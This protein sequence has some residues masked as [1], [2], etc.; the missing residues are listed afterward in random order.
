V[1]ASVWDSVVGQTSAVARLRASTAAP[2]HAYLFV[3]PPG[4][5]RL[6]A[7]RAFAADVLYP[8]ADVDGRDVRLVLHGEHPDV[9]E[10]YRVGPAISADQ[11]DE[12][13]RLAAMSPRE[14]SRKVLILDEFHLLR[15]EGAAKLLKTIEE[16][17]PSTMFIVLADQVP[18]ELVTIAS[19]CVR[20][21]FRPIPT[22]DIQAV[23]VAEGIDDAAAFD[24][25]EASNGDL[26]RAR[27]LAR[28]PDLVHRR[29]VF[30]GI[31]GRLDG[32]GNAVAMVVD[33]LQQLI[34]TA[35][36]PL[37]TR[38][39]A[40]LAAL[41][42]RVAATGER[43]SGRTQLVERQ[44]RELRRHRTDELR[45][46]LGVLAAAYRD[47]LVQGRGH[48]PSAYVDAVQRVHEAI[49]TLERNPNETLL[50]QN[51]LLHLPA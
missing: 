15:A 48:R 41:E 46:G 45:S 8:G 10:V 31:P 20:I 2:V 27:V 3:G 23:L 9:R 17:T 43:G 7:A 29:Q 36:A 51:L 14:G 32:S 25:A 44:K 38:H 42:E 39:A 30:A 37:A 40:E 11:A 6:E 34:E 5:T 35:A 18:P 22:A 12:I 26:D 49:E 24:A 28:D 1:T 50:L 21:D 19:R 33:E 16:P 13:V 47:A 4:S